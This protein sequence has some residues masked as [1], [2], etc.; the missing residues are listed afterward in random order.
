MVIQRWQSLFL[1]LSAV[2]MGLFSFLPIGE[3]QYLKDTFIISAMGVNLNAQTHNA[4]AAGFDLDFLYIFVTSL[5]STII[6]L[7]AVFCYK[8]MR[9]Q[10]RLCLIALLLTATTGVSVASEVY[11]SELS[12]LGSISLSWVAVLPLLSIVS[13]LIARGC[14]VSDKRKLDSY[15]RLR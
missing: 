7:I 3:I 1:L 13:I 6:P 8:Q 10:M 12:S 2:F 15:D 11:G 14:I 9:L 4:V 5:V